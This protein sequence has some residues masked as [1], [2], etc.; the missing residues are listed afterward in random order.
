MEE[1]LD[2]FAGLTQ[3]DGEL[4]TVETLKIVFAAAV[5]ARKSQTEEIEDILVSTNDSGSK[6]Q[7][8]WYAGKI[9][10]LV[11]IMTSLISEANGVVN[12]HL[13]ECLRSATNDWVQGIEYAERKAA[14]EII[15]A[16]LEGW[17]KDRHS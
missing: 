1:T 7:A 8:I 6:W 3:M 5:R 10:A 14:V 4:D 16:K 2:E 9:E 12:Q 15:I 17:Q 13:L 11:G